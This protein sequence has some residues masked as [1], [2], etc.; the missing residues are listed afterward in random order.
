MTT[1]DSEAP[2]RLAV[3]DADSHLTDVDDLWT[4]R[5]PAAY[6]D[7]I[8]HV[9]NID[10]ERTWVV[11]GLAVGKAG[12]GSTIDKAGVKHP[13]QESMVEWDFEKAHIGAWDIDTR[14]EVLDSMGIQHQVLY[15]NALG[16]GGQALADVK[17]PVLRNLCV[18]IFNDSRAEI[19]SR[20]NNRL[21]PMPIVP[22]WDIDACVREAQRISDMGLRGVNMTSDPQDLGSP[23]LANRAWDPLWEVCADLELPVHFHIGS[24]LTAMNFFGQYFWESQHEYVKPAIGG[25]MLFIG[26]ARVVINTIFAGVFDRHPKLKMVSV[27]SGIGWI[28]FILE[29]M[30]WELPENAPAQAAELD[31]APSEYFK[32][33]WYATMWFETG[34]GQLQELVDKI[35]EDN[36][37]FETDFP[38]PTSLWPKPLEHVH[39]AMATLRP[40]TRRKILAENGNKLYR[41][42]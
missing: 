9:E 21:L 13:F 35:G 18:E 33:N 8:L 31:R 24:S 23:D 36:I 4:K 19:Q 22:S 30:D 10:G 2:E 6:K 7:Q 5:A 11:E 1:L 17:D 39:D 37:M 3:L 15:P 27:E 28:P 41:L 32:T 14:L 34:R 20:T 40:E 38:H 12:G 26:N 29:T 16:L 25:A 42:G